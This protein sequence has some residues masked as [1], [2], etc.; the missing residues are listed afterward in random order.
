MITET[1]QRSGAL[2][3]ILLDLSKNESFLQ[4][5]QQVFSVWLTSCSK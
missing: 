3:S 1:N 5:V 4:E 2:C